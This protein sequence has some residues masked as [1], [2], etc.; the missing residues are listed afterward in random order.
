MSVDPQTCVHSWLAN[1]GRG[2]DPEFRP[3]QI[4]AG[5]TPVMHVLCEHCGCRT[6]FS[7]AKWHA[8]PRTNETRQERRRRL[9]EAAVLTRR[10]Q[11]SHARVIEQRREEFK[12]TGATWWNGEPAQCRRVIVRVGTVERPTWWCAGLE[13]QERRAVEVSYGGQT[14]LLDDEDGSGWAKVTIGR[15]SPGYGHSSLPRDS[16]VLREIS[17]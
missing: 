14:F 13:G 15:G 3:A 5:D 10:Q 2:G 1:S 6:W 17:Q 7:E 8:L 12:R 11:E 16:E 9:R 4:V